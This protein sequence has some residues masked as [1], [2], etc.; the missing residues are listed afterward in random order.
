MYFEHSHNL[1][2][3]TVVAFFL[4]NPNRWSLGGGVAYSLGI[5]E[6]EPLPKGLL[7]RCDNDPVLTQS[8]TQDGRLILYDSGTGIDTDVR[9][10]PDAD[11]VF[12]EKRYCLFQPKAGEKHLTSTSRMKGRS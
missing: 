6:R 3:C 11:G 1:A 12:R 5:R 9:I 2:N 8:R 10:K 4:V 7:G